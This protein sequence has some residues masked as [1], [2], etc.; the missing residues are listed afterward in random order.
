MKELFTHDY[1]FFQIAINK[2]FLKISV[3]KEFPEVLSRFFVN[4]KIKFITWQKTHIKKN[5]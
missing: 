5:K 1:Y 3:I 4:F 2:T